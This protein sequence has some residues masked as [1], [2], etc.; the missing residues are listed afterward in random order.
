MQVVVFKYCKEN[1][2]L[3]HWSHCVHGNIR[4]Q[5]SEYN[6]QKLIKLQREVLCCYTCC[7]FKYVDGFLKYVLSKRTMTEVLQKYMGLENE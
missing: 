3:M 2:K 6:A 4:V 5:V 1:D 7:T